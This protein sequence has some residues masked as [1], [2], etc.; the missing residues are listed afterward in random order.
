MVFAL[1][2]IFLVLPAVEIFLFIVVGE[3]IGALATIAL[4]F[5]AGALGI[6]L[7]RAQG[8]QTMRRAQASIERGEAP[9]REAVEG[10]CLFIAGMLLIVPGFFTDILAL[11]LFL[12]ATRRVMARAMAARMTAM[13]AARRGGTARSSAASG[14]IEGDF[15]VMPGANDN[16][17]PPEPPRLP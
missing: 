8:L 10:L 13:G 3:A 16:G 2:L 5:G 14:V 9:V 6:L 15:E 17:N 12:P 7:V 1:I 4:V 11:L